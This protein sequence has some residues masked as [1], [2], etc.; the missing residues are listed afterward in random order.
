MRAHGFIA[1]LGAALLLVVASARA[2]TLDDVFRKANQAYARGDDAA[3]IAG[4]ESLL[5]AGVDDPIVAYNLGTAH[6]RQGRYGQ[7]VRFFEQSLRLEPRDSVTLSALDKAK[8]A[9]GEKLAQKR[10]EAV[11]QTRAP[12]SQAVFARITCDGLSIGL[13]SCSLLLSLC[14]FGLR[15]LRDESTRLALGIAGSLAGLMAAI[16]GIGLGVK[17]DWGRPGQRAIVIAEE[18]VLRD[19]PDEAASIRF[20]LAEGTRVRLL[21][22]EGAFVEVEAGPEQRGYV[23]AGDVGEI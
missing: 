7:A 14:L 10:G 1:A 5:G 20:S 8:K 9:L 18:A 16:A 23:Q 17:T 12:L 13:L 19:G 6:A 3:A 2:E 21:S 22:R 4:Y 15:F 11:V